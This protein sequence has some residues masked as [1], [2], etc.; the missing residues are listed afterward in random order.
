[1]MLQNWRN[2]SA[3][4]RFADDLI[5]RERNLKAISTEQDAKIE[6]AKGESFRANLKSEDA[7][8]RQ[9]FTEFVKACQAVVP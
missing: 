7:L 6:E 5:Q 9:F 2:K 4:Q 1:M 8:L 3:L